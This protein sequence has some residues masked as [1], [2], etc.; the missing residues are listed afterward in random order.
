MRMASG[1][2]YFIKVFLDLIFSN[3]MP[4][5]YQKPHTAKTF[6]N[7]SHLFMLMGSDGSLIELTQLQ[8]N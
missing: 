7:T 6:A 8:F 3:H 1:F 4:T 2:V 5:S